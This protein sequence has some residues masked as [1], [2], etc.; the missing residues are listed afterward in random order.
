MIQGRWSHACGTILC[1]S[2]NNKMSAIVVGGNNDT[3]L[4]S[5]E[6]LDSDLGKTFISKYFKKNLQ[7]SF[8]RFDIVFAFFKSYLTNKDQIAAIISKLIINCKIIQSTRYPLKTWD[9]KKQ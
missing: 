4:S 9:A 6:I 5:V 2:K 8:D 3:F 7:Y 1:S